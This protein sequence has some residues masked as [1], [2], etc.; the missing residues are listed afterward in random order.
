MPWPVDQQIFT[1]I[2]WQTSSDAP[3]TGGTHHFA[4]G[5]GAAESGP[6]SWAACP[7]VPGEPRRTAEG[8]VH[9][10]ATQ[11]SEVYLCAKRVTL[12][13]VNSIPGEIFFFFH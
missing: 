4:P 2:S 13:R 5:L 11:R 9:A 3:R 10:E 12:D 1:R 7:E 8:P 6:G